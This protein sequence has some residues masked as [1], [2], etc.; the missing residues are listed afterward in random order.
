MPADHAERRTGCI[1]QNPIE[2]RPI[3]PRAGRGCVAACEI[4]PEITPCQIL[5]D[6]LEALRVDVD[7]HELAELRLALGHQRGFSAW[8]RAGVENPLARLKIQRKRD[9]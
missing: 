5:L 6:P 3:P 9:A 4:C 7:G 2:G 8:C 1:E